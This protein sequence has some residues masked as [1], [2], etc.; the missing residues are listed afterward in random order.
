V[1]ATANIEDKMIA[2]KGA[3]KTATRT[4]SGPLSP[5]NKYI[6]E[7]TPRKKRNQLTKKILNRPDMTAHLSFQTDSEHKSYR[8][9]LMI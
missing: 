1:K 3:A 8:L 6:R 5:A 4:D 7:K 9:A 2:Q